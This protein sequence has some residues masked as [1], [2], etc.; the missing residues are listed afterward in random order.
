M[1][2]I[3]RKFILGWLRAAI[4]GAVFCASAAAQNSVS[5]IVFDVN[6]KPVADIELELL[7][8][9]ERLI[10]ATRTNGSGLYVFQGLRGGVFYV[11]V[12][13]DGTNYRPVKERVQLG[14]TN[15]TSRTTGAI[16]GS[17]SLQIN[18]T[19]E[20][21]TRAAPAA[22]SNE[23]VFAQNV[24]DEAAKHFEAALKKLRDAK[25]DEAI[26][27][28]EKALAIYPDYFLA[29]EKIGYEYLLK[30]KFAESE[31]AF[32]RASQVNPKSVAAKSG[33]GIAQYKLGKRREAAQT[34]EE[35]TAVNQ[36]SPNSFLFLGK[37]YRELKDY[38][39][40][41]TNLKKAKELAKNKLA[42][43]HWELAL[44]FYYNLNRP[45]EA[46]DELELYLRAK[47]D[48]ANKSQVE[49]LIKQMREKAREKS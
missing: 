23:V 8:E 36:S 4:L 6:R 5:G 40:A 15:R 46:A 11:Q 2:N 22:L 33:L 42:D 31:T 44:L 37:I 13:V 10:R 18:F 19:L 20:A 48:A 38:A 3:T 27:E 26:A 1:K 7:D 16:S 14:Q 29:L 21:K 9:F 30:G 12:R 47:P 32:T 39:R 34:L 43:V 45:R 17:E 35:S 24:P 25:P 41:E 49:K 28:L